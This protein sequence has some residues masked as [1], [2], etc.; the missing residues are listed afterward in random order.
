MANKN[1][2]ISFR[3]PKN[4]D[5]SM[6]KAINSLNYSSKNEF[7]RYSVR[8]TLNDLLKKKKKMAP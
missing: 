2:R 5:K 4:W 1:K 8:K 7:I 3:Y 6:K